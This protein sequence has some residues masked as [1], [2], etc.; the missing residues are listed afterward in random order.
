M[1]T[2]THTSTLSYARLPPVASSHPAFNSGTSL[3]ARPTA[4]I[5][6]SFRLTFTPLASITRLLSAA[7]SLRSTSALAY[8]CG[9]LVLLSVNR[10]AIVRRIFVVAAS[11]AACA[12]ASPYS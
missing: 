3:N 4:Y 5:T 1:A 6:Q 2:A 8:A 11:S 9:V 12:R 7:T 10:L